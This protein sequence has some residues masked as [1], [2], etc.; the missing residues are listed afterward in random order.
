[1]EKERK[2]QIIKA[3]VKRFD[4]HGPNKT[5]LDEIARDLRI[6]KATIYG[7][8]KSK[9]ELY[10]AALDWEGSLYLEDIKTIFGSEGM[11]IR[12]RF[13][14]YFDLKESIPLKYKLIQD[15]L[16]QIVG[17]K[18]FEN[19][20]TFF[21]NLLSAEEEIIRKELS[22]ISSAGS[23][24]EVMLNASEI[25]MQSWGLFLGRKISASVNNQESIDTKNLLMKL[26]S[27]YKLQ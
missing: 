7:Y 4:K 19:E 20:H 13:L 16:I 24:Q 10:F 21:K 15:T 2:L 23:E 27:S 1:M 25:V 12:E 5:T 11:P 18:A 22:N 3:S 14:N 8:F 6:G 9:E 17:E 26:I